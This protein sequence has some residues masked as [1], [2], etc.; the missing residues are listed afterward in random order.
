MP[1]RR[2]SW[3]DGLDLNTLWADIA[4]LCKQL[5]IPVIYKQLSDPQYLS[6]ILIRICEVSNV[7]FRNGP[8]NRE[9]LRTFIDTVLE[10]MELKPRQRPVKKVKYVV[11]IEIP[12]VIVPIEDDDSDSSIIIPPDFNDYEYLTVDSI[13]MCLYYDAE[14]Q[15][16][17]VEELEEMCR[18]CCGDDSDDDYF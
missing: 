9:D 18:G 4:N 17:T 16:W 14:V 8:K 10:S 5:G 6:S 7:P 15:V 11:V 12:E 13:P 2:G 1:K 3:D